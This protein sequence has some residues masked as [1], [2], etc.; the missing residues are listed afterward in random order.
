MSQDQTTPRS[1]GEPESEW[2]TKQRA[3][4]EENARL[5]DALRQIA[6][7]GVGTK[8]TELVQI[9][10]AAITSAGT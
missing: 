4:R 10:L 3:L 5:R 7:C 6:D 8:P 9:A 2:L 1:W